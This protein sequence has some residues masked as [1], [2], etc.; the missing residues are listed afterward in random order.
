MDK[1]LATIAATLSLD[2]TPGVLSDLFFH[3]KDWERNL[4]SLA[5]NGRDRL[6]TLVLEKGYEATESGTRRVEIEGW[7]LEARPRRTG[8]DPKR[9]EALLRAKQLDPAK[10]MATEVKFVLSE[11]KLRQA[12]ED[13][14]MTN[15]E[16]QTCAYPLEFNLQTPKKIEE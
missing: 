7:E 5:K 2:L 1:T 11:E 6:L 15:D 12:L 3:I 4:E 13:G 9:L 8:V 10:Y 14:A 16:L